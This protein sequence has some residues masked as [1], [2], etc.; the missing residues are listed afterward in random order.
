MYNTCDQLPITRQG[1]PLAHLACRDNVCT[2]NFP[3]AELNTQ[4]ECADCKGE[5]LPTSQLAAL[6]TAD[7]WEDEAEVDDWEDLA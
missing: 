4:S 7:D 1:L 2:L 3:A 6:T 5:S